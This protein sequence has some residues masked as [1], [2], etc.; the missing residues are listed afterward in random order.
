M[1][2]FKL[3]SGEGIEATLE[4]SEHAP[5]QFEIKS[6]KSHYDAVTK[7]VTELEAQ[8]RLEEAIMNNV[9]NNHEIMILSDEIRQ[10]CYLYIKSKMAIT[11]AQD[12]LDGLKQSL[13]EYDKE[14]AEVKEQT[15]LDFHA[16]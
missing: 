4:K 14:L 15:G 8:I 3:I 6:V 1:P 5:T 7:A 13:S 9:A 11:G 10:A 16:L 12:K 2:K